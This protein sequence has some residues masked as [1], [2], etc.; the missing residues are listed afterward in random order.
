MLRIKSFIYNEPGWKTGEKIEFQQSN[1]IVGRN[2]VGKSQLLKKIILAVKHI[3]QLQE[4]N[5][6]TSFL[7]GFEFI[8]ADNLP[9]S[10][11]FAYIEGEVQQE[12]FYKG[13]NLEYPII[14]RDNSGNCMLNGTKVTPPASKLV[15]NVRRDIEQFPDIEMLFEWAENTIAI[16]FN[17]LDLYGDDRYDSS[18]GIRISLYDMVKA[19]DAESIEHILEKCMQIGYPLKK[20]EAT[21]I[22]TFKKVLFYEDSVNQVL[23][24]RLLS[25][26]MFRVVYVLI[27][28]EYLSMQ[29]YNGT[30]IID[31]F[32]E[33]LDYSRSTKLGKLL[34]RYCEEKKIQL[35]VTSNDSFLMDVVDM[36][37]WNV[38]TRK[39]G[40]LE[41]LNYENSKSMFDDFAFTGMSNFDFFS[42]DFIDRYKASQS[43]NE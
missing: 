5:K 31:D 6:N 25:K 4:P 43:N 32:C 40:T 19:L 11:Q 20:M 39:G 41:T 36:T 33:G 30:L 42:S 28:I 12:V 27:L 9:Y 21:E 38:L 10:Y 7:V 24:D 26:G 1:L 15:V 2:S 23:F 34:F 35:I 14:Y 37:K 8:S 18:F 22:G 17:E 29:T 3:L 16:S 13:N